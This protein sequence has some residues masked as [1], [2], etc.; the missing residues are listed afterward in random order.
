LFAKDALLSGFID[1]SV[2]VCSIGA[3]QKRHDAT[4]Y[5]TEQSM[6]IHTTSLPDILRIEPQ[7]LS[8]ERAEIRRIV[9]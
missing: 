7:V 8:H 6:R 9:G 1:Q 3:V 2:C 5:P 4:A